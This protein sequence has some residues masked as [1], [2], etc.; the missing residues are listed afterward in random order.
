MSFLVA[1]DFAY[2]SG[3]IV[4]VFATIVVIKIV[5]GKWFWE[6]GEEK[7]EAEKK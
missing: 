1:V 5:C 4:G 7:K 2:F 3:A 6:I